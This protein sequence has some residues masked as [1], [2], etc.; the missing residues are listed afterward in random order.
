MAS[1]TSASGDSPT[2]KYVFGPDVADPVIDMYMKYWFDRGIWERDDNNRTPLMEAAAKHDE[3]D[4]F[5]VLLAANRTLSMNEFHRYV[6]T[7]NNN[8]GD[9]AIFCAVAEKETPETRSIVQMLLENGANLHSIHGPYNGCPLHFAARNCLVTT[10]ETFINHG[11]NV[12]AVSNWYKETPLHW[13][14]ETDNEGVARLLIQRGADIHALSA[15]HEH[16]PDCGNHGTCHGAMLEGLTP[17]HISI[18]HGSPRVARLLLDHG[19]N[20]Y[21]LQ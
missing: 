5:M 21:Y 16:V 17:L 15:F 18:W 1:T 2:A 12:H 9:S 3:A 4:V 13:A 6:R 19:A 14:A 11:D 10:V 7:T 20:L 8:F